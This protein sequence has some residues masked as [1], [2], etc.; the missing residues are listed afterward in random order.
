MTSKRIA[1][2]AC[3]GLLICTL[4]GALVWNRV[5]RVS[6]EPPTPYFIAAA[7]E[8][9]EAASGNGLEVNYSTTSGRADKVSTMR[10]HYIRTPE[11]LFAEENFPNLKRVRYSYD[12]VAREERSIVTSLRST[13]DI[14]PGMRIPR[15]SGHV[16][17]FL[18]SPFTN[19]NF[20]ETT[21]AVLQDGL[22]CDV[23]GSGTVHAHRE[24]V[25]GHLCW[26][27]DVSSSHPEASTKYLVWV[28]SEIG[29]CPRQIKIVRT[30][31]PDQVIKFQDY[32]DLG[33]GV[34]FPRHHTVDLDDGDGPPLHVESHVADAAINKT[35]P[36]ESL[37][38]E[39]PSGTRVD[40]LGRGS[41][42]EP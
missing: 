41:Y 5:A 26:R 38:V 37:L 30:S 13:T 32:V 27:V 11:V 7:L 4:T 40:V 29:Y 1:V 16:T 24:D 3:V 18:T 36:K 15:V 25:D 35:F 22:I 33:S 8:H 31:L 14:K 2:A 17:G 10:V 19:T 20:I 34:W 42:V 39:F 9:Q 28:D 12:R 21:R 23:I 6:V